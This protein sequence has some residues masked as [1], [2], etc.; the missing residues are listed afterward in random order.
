MRYHIHTNG[1]AAQLSES[2]YGM[3]QQRPPAGMPAGMPMGMPV[4]CRRECRREIAKQ[5]AVMCDG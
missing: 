2:L 3:S 5:A 1:S 4:E